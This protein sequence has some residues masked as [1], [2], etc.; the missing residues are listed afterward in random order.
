MDP[1][2]HAYRVLVPAASRAQVGRYKLSIELMD[3]WDETIGDNVKFCFLGAAEVEVVCSMGFFYETQTQLCHQRDICQES[4]VTPEGEH[5]FLALDS[6]DVVRIGESG[7]LV[8]NMSTAIARMAEAQEAQ[9]FVRLV[10]LKLTKDFA[11][12]P[13]G[14]ISVDLL[15]PGNFSLQ[16]VGRT[17]HG[18][19]SQTF[20]CLLADSVEVR[21]D[22]GYTSLSGGCQL[23]SS[24]ASTVQVSMGILLSSLLIVGV[25]VAV[26]YAITHR[27]STKALIVDFFSN[28]LMMIV[29]FLAEL[30]CVLTFPRNPGCVS[31]RYFSCVA[32]DVVSDVLFYKSVF[33]SSDPF[34]SKVLVPWTGFICLSLLVS[35]FA[36]MLR[37]RVFVHRR[38]HLASQVQ[39]AHRSI[40]DALRTSSQPSV[41]RAC[42]SPRADSEASSREHQL[43]ELHEQLRVCNESLHQAYTSLLTAVF[44]DFPLAVLSV[45][46][47][48]MTTTDQLKPLQLISML[49]SMAMLGFK[50]SKVQR[51]M[52]L[53]SRLE[54]LESSPLLATSTTRSS[55]TR[56]ALRSLKRPMPKWRSETRLMADAGIE[57]DDRTDFDPFSTEHG[58]GSCAPAARHLVRPAA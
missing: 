40:T 30:W 5:A 22:E 27:E 12:K 58:L 20:S 42:P 50:C 13:D 2:S 51:I 9:Y 19:A 34:R 52:D 17:T 28:E 21:C 33:D 32:R 14:S 23:V 44:E 56:N 49:W 4:R 41:P 48:Y 10:P 29:S 6:T 18:L 8:V 55:A 35:L 53:W 47:V 38:R 15:E 36:A 7:R 43:H 1:K 3:A 37:V 31:W 11:A 24:G 57:L 26:A 16:V 54:A 25:S 45:I 39:R 46:W